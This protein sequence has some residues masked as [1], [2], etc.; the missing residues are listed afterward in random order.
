MA[1]S[2]SEAVIAAA[3]FTDGLI[4]ISKPNNSKE[5]FDKFDQAAIDAGKDPTK[6][7]KIGK[8]KYHIL[9][10][11]MRHSNPQIS[12]EQARLKMYLILSLMIQEN[13]KK[14]H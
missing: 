7:E 2:G 5:I 14:V 3:T 13:Y 10:I 1:A 11:T 9:R 12:G 4:T 6:L 8:P